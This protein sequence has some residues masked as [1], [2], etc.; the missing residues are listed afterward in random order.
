MMVSKLNF[1]SELIIKIKF[2]IENESSDFEDLGDLS[3]YFLKSFFLLNIFRNIKKWVSIFS[4]NPND[5]FSPCKNHI[6]RDP[7]NFKNDSTGADSEEDIIWRPKTCISTVSQKD[8]FNSPAK[9]FSGRNSSHQFKTKKCLKS[10]EEPVEEKNFNSQENIRSKLRKR[11]NNGVN[12]LQERNFNDYHIIKKSSR[13]KKATK[14]QR[15]S[16]SMAFF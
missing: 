1:N 7:R 12:L 15:K 2:K 5:V 6:L 16:K 8:A 4:V 10:H 14:N 11:K 13:V 9:K 3:S